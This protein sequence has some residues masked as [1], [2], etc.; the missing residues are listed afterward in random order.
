MLLEKRIN[1]EVDQGKPE[2]FVDIFWR[3]WLIPVD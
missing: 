2:D 1:L 3:D